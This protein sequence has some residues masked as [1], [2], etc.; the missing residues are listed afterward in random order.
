M[1]LDRT[2]INMNEVQELIKDIDDSEK[3]EKIESYLKKFLKINDKQSTSIKEKIESLDS[4]KIKREHIVKINDII[5]EDASDLSK[6]FIDV[7]LSEEEINK[8]IQIVKSLR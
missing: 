4:I 3:K 7:N 1:I 5:P 2:P 8:L 6:I